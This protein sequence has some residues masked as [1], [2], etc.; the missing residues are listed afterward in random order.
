MLK[1]VPR[2]ECLQAAVARVPGADPAICQVFL[3]ILHT[4]DVV[5]RGRRRFWRDTD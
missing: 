5:S 4:G 2:Y 3:N 1:E